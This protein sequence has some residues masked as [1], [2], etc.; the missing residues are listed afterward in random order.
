MTNVMGDDGREPIRGSAPD[1]ASAS[2]EGRTVVPV[3]NLWTGFVL[4]WLVVLV[5]VG[6]MLAQD[7][8][9]RPRLA[10]VLVGLT[11]LGAL[12]LVTTLSQAIGPADLVSGRPDGPA[13]RRR[14]ALLGAMTLLVAALVLLLPGAGM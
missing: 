5:A 10:V 12:Y 3:T 11:L 1:G 9:F 7:R 14:M 8:S 2:V 6:A 13:L 4:A